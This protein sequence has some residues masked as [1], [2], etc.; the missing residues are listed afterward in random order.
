MS[1]II[2]GT[3]GI[4][5]PSGSGTQAA[6]SKVLQV[7]QAV[8]NTGA[9]ST[10]STSFVTT[11]L[12]ASITPLFSTS[13]V[14]I[15]VSTPITNTVVN[16]VTNLTV[17]RGG[18]NLGGNVN[19]ALSSTSNTGSGYIWTPASISYLDSPSTTSS[20]T[21]TLYFNTSSGGTAYA[22]W[23]ACTS[24]ITLMEIAA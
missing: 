2:D 5:F 14:L 13:K 4:T 1:V 21:Y 19:S 17:Y 12:A 23:G 3:A 22:L 11:G 16:G 7:V 24:M 10:T 8:W 20:T 9:P 18:T 6:Q 15:V